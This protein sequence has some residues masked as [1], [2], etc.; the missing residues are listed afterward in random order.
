MYKGFKKFCAL[1]MAVVTAMSAVP[2][3]G[4]VNADESSDLEY[5]GKPYIQFY[6]PNGNGKLVVSSEQNDVQ[7]VYSKDGKY[8]LLDEDDNVIED[9]DMSNQD[10]ALEIEEELGSI[11]YTRVIPDKGYEVATY[12]ILADTGDVLEECKLSSENEYELEV[13]DEATFVEVTFKKSDSDKEDTDEDK[14]KLYKGY[15]VDCSEESESIITVLDSYNGYVEVDGEGFEE[16]D[17]VELI[18]HPRKGYITNLVIVSLDETDENLIADLES[19][20]DDEEATIDYS[21]EVTCDEDGIYSFE[22]PSYS[23]LVE[24]RYIEDV[25]EERVISE[26]KVYEVEDT[27]YTVTILESENGGLEVLDADEI[28]VGQDIVVQ[29][30]PEKGYRTEIV[31]AEED[32]DTDDPVLLD[33]VDEG[34]DMYSFT[35]P[36]YSIRIGVFYIEEDFVFASQE[37]ENMEQKAN[38]LESYNSRAVAGESCT[39]VPSSGTLWYGSWS[40]CTFSVTTSTGSH[41]G[42]CAEPD[43]PTPNG[44]Y[45]VSSLNNDYIL[46]AMLC[47]EITE[48]YNNIGKNLY[49]EADNNMY[50]YCH[51]T[52]GYLYNGSLTGL[53]VNMANGIKNVANW[54]VA[55]ND[56][57]PG[58]PTT[59]H[60]MV[61]KYKPDYKLFVAYNSYQDIVWMEKMASTGTYILKKNANQSSTWSDKMINQYNGL[62]YGV[63]SD[64]ACTNKVDAVS[65][66]GSTATTSA[67]S[68]K[69]GTYYVKESVNSENGWYQIN[70]TV[71]TLTIKS[72]QQ[73]TL[74]VYDD[75]KNTTVT[76]TKTSAEPSCTNDNPAYS[77]EGAEY[78]VYTNN[79]TLI[80]TVTTDAN[81]KA[82][83]TVNPS[84][85]TDNVIRIKETK[86]PKG[87][88]KDTEEHVVFI[89][90]CSMMSSSQNTTYTWSSGNSSK[91]A[92]DVDSDV[93]EKMSKVVSLSYDHAYTDISI[94]HIE[95]PIYDPIDILLKKT[96][97]VSGSSTPAGSG[98]LEG[99]QFEVKYYAVQMSTD[100]AKSGYSPVKTWMLQTDSDGYLSLD[101]TYKISGP[102]F[103]YVDGNTVLPLGTVTFQEKVAPDGYALNEEMIVAQITNTDSNIAVYQTPTIKEEPVTFVGTK[104]YKNYSTNGSYTLETL[105]GATFKWTKPDGSTETCVSD[106]NGKFYFYGLVNGT[107]TFEEIATPDG[108][109]VVS[110]NYAKVVVKNNKIDSVSTSG[111]QTASKGTSVISMT[112]NN[113][114]SKYTVDVNKTNELSFPLSNAEFTI[115]SD[116]ACTKVISTIKTGTDGMSDKVKLDVG[117]TYY[118]KETKAPVG[119]RIPVNDDGSD[120]VYTLVATSNPA[121]N[122]FEIRVNGVVYNSNTTDAVKVTGTK[123]DRAVTFHIV[124]ERGM[125]LPNTGSSMMLVLMFIGVSLMGGALMLSKKRKIVVLK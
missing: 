22:M 44:T 76:L 24:A 17:T 116:S 85:T 98:T 115:Y 112:L 124:N 30:K 121:T 111:W 65:F 93:N 62:W 73:T 61:E 80:K 94:T 68:L 1:A 87:Y 47:Y 109:D 91:S 4:L 74:N 39:I 59:M 5:L 113:L 75:Y 103:W 63:Y 81:G 78:S 45:T 15:T 36:D 41:L 35:M 70:D 89:S 82:T 10:Y 49:N 100:P 64:Y 102:D 97:S 52:I 88:Q 50:A 99:A 11:V 40:T 19:L 105:K 21:V 25:E 16:G 34:N 60:N 55:I 83:F 67:R 92:R 86:A 57:H 117:K 32:A 123:K 7:T 95:Q 84:E 96:D 104:Y 42:Y 53:S 38:V 43:S 58:D 8:S 56:S 51:A 46:T 27:D 72:G 101:N 31:I 106:E 26:E 114:A 79:G 3:S 20:E 120:I 9:V 110:G 71:Y 54:V 122:K 13:T 69:A 125:K 37:S 28:A 29:S 90:Y 2:T 118:M 18:S 23:V 119:Y 33:V 77:L 108:Y 66:T 14:A 107:H 6:I 48:L 12:S